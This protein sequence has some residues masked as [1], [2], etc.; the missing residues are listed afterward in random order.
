MAIIVNSPHDGNPV[1]VRDQ[2]I[3]R[4]IRDGEGRIF[5]AVKRSDGQGYYGALTRKGSDK[6]EQRYLEMI[7]KMKTAR[8]TG[9]VRS[10]AQIHD[11]TG[12]QTGPGVLAWVILLI[13]ALLIAAVTWYFVKPDN[14]TLPTSAPAPQTPADVPAGDATLDM[15]VDREI[16]LALNAQG[17]VG[18]SSGLHYKILQPGTGEPAVAGRYVQIQYMGTT[19]KGQ[20]FDRSEPGKPVGFVMWSGT[21]PR[22]WEE[23]VTG[24]RVGEKRRLILAPDLMCGPYPGD[25]VVPDGVLRFDIELVA[26]LPS[27]RYTR[28]APGE[29]EI[30]GPGDIVQVHFLAYLNREQTCYDSTYDRGEPAEFRVGTGEVIPGWDM[31]VMGMTEGEKRTIE[32]PSYLGYGPRGAAGIIPPGANLRYTVELVRVNGSVERTVDASQGHGGRAAVW[33]VN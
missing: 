16:E 18:T 30:A 31:G 3:E 29:G 28:E 10:D 2:D 33:P 17:Y 15:L 4:A 22:G 1:K 13:V 26:V 14:S 24:M 32:I 21:V 19:N 6:D 12:K 23:G 25:V 27:I 8:D 7:E 20:V 11:A 9:K 5:Y